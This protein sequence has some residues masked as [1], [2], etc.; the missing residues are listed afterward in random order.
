MV[1]VPFLKWGRIVAEE[2]NL[3]TVRAGGICGAVGRLISER[4]EEMIYMR[5]MRR[6]VAL[7]GLAVLGGCVVRVEPPHRRVYV[8][9]PPPAPVEVVPVQPEVDMIWV[10]GVYVREGPEWRWHRGYWRHR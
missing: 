10:P 9:D 7:A 3:S 5:M 6:V 4:F 2:K 1:A 8:Y